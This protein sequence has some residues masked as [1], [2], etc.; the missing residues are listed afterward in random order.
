LR[1]LRGDNGEEVKDGSKFINGDVDGS[2]FMGEE[3]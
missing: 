2:A 3:E 1:I